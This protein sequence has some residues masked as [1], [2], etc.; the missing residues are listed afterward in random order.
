M[1]RNE[2]L[3][4]RFRPSAVSIADPVRKRAGHSLTELAV[5]SIAMMAIVGPGALPAETPTANIV[6]LGATTCSTFNR[7]VQQDFRIQRDYFAWAQ[8]FM[9]GILVRGPPGR[10]EGLELI[11][12]G[13]SMQKQV[14][15]L[16][17]YCAENP[18]KD[19]S[20][21]V[22]DLYRALRGEHKS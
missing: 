1:F 18:D 12:S 5:A 22:V 7:D 10:N 14:E 11:P 6:G 19:Y 17:T 3:S 20:D 4:D 21:G 13:F 8:G 15:F 16:R 9:S 2:V